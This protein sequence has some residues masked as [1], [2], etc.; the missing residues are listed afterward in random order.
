DGRDLSLLKVEYIPSPYA[1]IVKPGGYQ[2]GQEVIAI[3]SPLGLNSTVTTGVIS[4]IGR[5]VIRYDQIQMSAPINPGNSGGPLFNLTGEV[6]GINT[7]IITTDILFATWSGLGFS[8][9]ASEINRFLWKFHGIEK[10]L[11]R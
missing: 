7:N 5:D 11:R 8:V 6:V 9:S 4:A 10:A 3:G 2:V 1:R